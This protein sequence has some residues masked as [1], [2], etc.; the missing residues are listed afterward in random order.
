ML[1]AKHRRAEIASAQRDSPK[2]AHERALSVLRAASIRRWTL[3]RRNPDVEMPPLPRLV[4]AR[5]VGTKIS[6]FTGRDS[7]SQPAVQPR[8][9]SRCTVR[10]RR[11]STP[12]R[13]TACG[14]TYCPDETLVTTGPDAAAW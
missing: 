7:P 11:R 1:S 6:G 14:M 12:R 5:K 13:T 2:G 9:A 8:R 4:A 3:V 10:F